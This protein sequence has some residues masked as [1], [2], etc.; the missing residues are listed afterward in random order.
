MD[1]SYNGTIYQT[2]CGIYDFTSDSWR[3]V[4]VITDWF[5]V[6]SR[7]GVFVNGNTYWPA[8]LQ[9]SENDFL[10]SFDFS[11]ERFQSFSLQLEVPRWNS[12]VT[13]SVTKEGQQLCMLV[14]HNEEARTDVWMA[15]SESTGALSWSKFLTVSRSDI[16]YRC[17]FWSGMSFLADQENK[18]ILSCN[19]PC[20]FYKDTIHI[21]GEDIYVKLDHHGVKPT[22]KYP[23]SLLLISYVPSLVQI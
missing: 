2:D 8:I 5:L 15:K 10:L 21:V 11:T 19:Y 9:N 22:H 17:Q 18:V 16:T 6:S 3:G 23:N 13:L 14:T 20:G 12:H 7:R 1:V 4:G